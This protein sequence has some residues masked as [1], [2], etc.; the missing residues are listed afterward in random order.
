MACTTTLPGTQ[1]WP[2]LTPD[3]F[4]CISRHV[5]AMRKDL[6]R[7]WLR[8]LGAGELFLRP[9]P[10]NLASYPTWRAQAGRFA[11]GSAAL[12]PPSFLVRV[13]TPLRGHD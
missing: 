7:G 9:S 12:G 8:M 3:Q 4:Q 2:E 6:P 13:S 10:I 1:A 11:P 5:L